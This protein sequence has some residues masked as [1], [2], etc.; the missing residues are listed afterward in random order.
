[1]VRNSG[2]DKTTATDKMKQ[3]IVSFYNIRSF[4]G[5]NDQSVFN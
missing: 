1:M 2:F 4:P 5:V 3:L